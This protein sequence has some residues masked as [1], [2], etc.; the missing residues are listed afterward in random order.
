MVNWFNRKKK[1]RLI[2]DIVFLYD[3]KYYLKLYPDE[4]KHPCIPITVVKEGQLSTQL[5]AAI[6][7]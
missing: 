1:E 6:G 4:D 7:S 3:C 5:N 2:D